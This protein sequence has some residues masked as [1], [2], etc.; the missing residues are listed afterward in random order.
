MLESGIG[1]GL[2]QGACCPDC[3]G[4]LGGW[5]SY[6]RWVR[7]MGEIVLLLVRRVAC[8]ACRRTH[9]LLPSFLYARRLDGSEVI[10]GALPMA[11]QGAGHRRVCVAVGVPASTARGW[12]RRARLIASERSS[13]FVVLSQALGAPLA[14]APPRDEPLAGL[15]EA[16]AHAHRAAVERFGALAVSSGGA[17]SCAVC[18]GQMLANTSWLFPGSLSAIRVWLTGE[19]DPKGGTPGE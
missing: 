14:R 6:P 16:V 2:S 19:I 11:A 17:F 18:A 7:L 1:P 5:G 10:F 12:L 13:Q 15:L 4:A 3:G 9:A 8:V